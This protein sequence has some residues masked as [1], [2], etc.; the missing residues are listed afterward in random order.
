MVDLSGW[1]QGHPSGTSRLRDFP[2]GY[3]SDKSLIKR[4]FE[5]EHY[6]DD[7]SSGSAG[8]HKQGSGVLPT[9]TGDGEPSLGTAAYEIMLTD[10]TGRL[11]VS[12]SNVSFPQPLSAGTGFGLVVVGPQSLSTTNVWTISF[13]TAET[14]SFVTWNSLGPYVDRPYVFYE[15]VAPFQSINT[16]SMTWLESFDT[17]GGTFQGRASNLNDNSQTSFEDLPSDDTS[18]VAFLSIGQVARSVVS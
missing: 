10:D 8:V 13:N 14:G 3:R 11:Y 17:S 2:G 1:T 16:V 18:Y 6:F 9:R 15:A 12:G 5:Q 4:A 7:G